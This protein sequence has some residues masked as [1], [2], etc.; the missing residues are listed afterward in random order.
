[1]G[2]LRNDNHYG[3][4]LKMYNDEYWDFILSL[5]GTMGANA[6]WTGLY[7]T[8]LSSYIDTNNTVCWGTSGELYSA[9]GYAWASAIN[10]GVTTCDW[11]ICSID[12]GGTLFTL[13]EITLSDYYKILTGTTLT[14]PSGDTRFYLKPV[15]GNTMLYK[16]PMESAV[17]DNG[18]RYEKLKGGFWQGFMK[19]EGLDYAVLPTTVEDEWTFEITLRKEDYT[20]TKGTLNAEYPNNKGMFFYIGTRAEDK[21]WE[22]YPNADPSIYDYKGCTSIYYF[23]DSLCGLSGMASGPTGDTGTICA[24]AGY[25]IDCDYQQILSGLTGIVTCDG[26]PL[27]LPGYYEF[28]SSNKY[29]LFNHTC[30]GYTVDTWE[31]TGASANEFMWTGYTS[32]LTGTEY[33]WYNRTCTGLTTETDSGA[34]A[35][36]KSSSFKYD[37]V[38]DI[39]GNALGFMITSGNAVGYRYLVRDCEETSVTKYKIMEEKSLDNII[40]TNNWTTIDVKLRILDGNV[41]SCGRAG[42]NRH[43]RLYFYVDGYLKFISQELPALNLKKINEVWEKQVGVPYNISIGGGSQGLAETMLADPFITPEYEL[44]IEKYFAGSFLGDFKSF[45]FYTCPITLAE[46]RANVTYEKSIII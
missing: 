15:S 18:T 38:G 31:S 14:I 43:M 23:G 17:T 40:T 33:Y 8:C 44:P 4:S 11:G 21:F 2:I 20:V 37:V 25:L 27:D 16:Y 39:V 12:N 1:M 5:D 6:G 28:E 13:S 35:Q 34:T 24:S 10:P 46:M 32:G 22:I 45:K 29:L 7:A 9:T 36:A 3:L 41:D 42:K 19:L 30:H 26:V